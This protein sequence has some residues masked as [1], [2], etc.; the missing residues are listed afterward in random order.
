VSIGWWLCTS[1]PS[2]W[3]NIY[4][5]QFHRNHLFVQNLHDLMSVIFDPFLFCSWDEDNKCKRVQ[6]TLSLTTTQVGLT[7]PRQMAFGK[8]GSQATI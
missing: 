2:C 5:F 8:L 1:A 4:I 6:M 7:L 3:T